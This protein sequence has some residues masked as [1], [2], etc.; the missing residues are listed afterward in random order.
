MFLFFF[1]WKKVEC[2][3]QFFNEQTL[4]ILQLKFTY[5]WKLPAFKN[6]THRQSDFAS[7]E[8]KVHIICTWT[9][10]QSVGGFSLKKKS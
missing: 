6:L 2:L 1:L 7:C 10:W 5:K 8:H 9:K 3:S 4:L